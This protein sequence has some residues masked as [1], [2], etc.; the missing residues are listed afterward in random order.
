MD[1]A[2]EGSAMTAS[3]SPYA[4]GLAYVDGEVCALADARLPLVEA[5]FTRSD[6]TY[7]VAAVWN[8][9][10]FRLDEHLARFQRSRDLLR[11]RPPEETPDIRRILMDMVG[12]SGLRAAYVSMIATR[13]C[14][15]PDPATRGA[16][17]IS[18]TRSL[19]LTS[20]FRSR[21][22]RPRGQ[23]G[24]ASVQRTPR[25]AFDPTIKNFQWVTYPG[26]LGGASP[27]RKP[28][29]SSTATG[30]SPRAPGTTSSPS[31]TGFS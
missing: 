29:S 2:M 17:R 3:D 31:S 26:S 19:A 27:A 23:R 10:F 30:T 16:M 1:S 24:E 8:G 14:R 18:S 25:A 28:A 20:G 15:S 12:R 22:A 7:D 21:G 5:G 6:V 13:G 11:L 9:K 4:Q